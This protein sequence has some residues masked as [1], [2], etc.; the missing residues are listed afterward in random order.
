MKTILFQ[1]DSITDAGR[2]TEGTK[3]I[4][5]G[6]PAMV[7]ANVGEKYPNDYKFINRAVS[8]NRIV[9]V[10]ARIKRDIINIKPDYLSIMIGTNDVWH[11]IGDDPNGVDS[12]KFRMLYD[13][14][15]SEITKALPKVKIIILTPYHTEK[16]IAWTDDF[17]QLVS[18]KA[19]IAKEMSIKYNTAFIDTQILIDEAVKR[20]P[21]EH[22]TADG[23]HPTIFGHK[24]FA[25]KYE[26]VFLELESLKNE[27]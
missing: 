1:G 18:E 15:L 5:F 24:V 9:D 17:K 23:V 4:G 25:K 6:Y 26:E 13:C 8:G 21:L 3:D 14:M 20:A 7:A 19:E 11:D 10:Y 12:D 16:T 27:G 22:W 2:F